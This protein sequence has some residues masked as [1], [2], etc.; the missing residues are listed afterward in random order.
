M[1]H[2]PLPGDHPFGQSQHADKPGPAG[3]VRIDRRDRE[4]CQVARVAHGPGQQQQPD[5]PGTAKRGPAGPACLAAGAGLPGHDVRAQQA[6]RDPG[7]DL[8][9]GHPPGYFASCSRPTG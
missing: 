4:C 5:R 6:D 8:A 7:P 9:R 2:D 3:A 1:D